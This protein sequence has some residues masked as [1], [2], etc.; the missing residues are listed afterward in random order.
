[1]PPGLLV[2]PS[3]GWGAQNPGCWSCWRGGGLCAGSLWG[4]RA[5]QL[6]CSP[7][8]TP[9]TTSTPSPTTRAPPWGDTTQPTARAPCPASGTASTTPGEPGVGAASRDPLL[10]ASHPRCSQLSS[11]P[12]AVSRRCPRAT[13]AAV[14][15]TCSS[16]SWP[17]RPPACSQPCLPGDPLCHPSEPAPLG[18]RHSAPPEQ[19][20]GEE[21]TPPRWLLGTARRRARARRSQRPTEEGL[22]T[23]QGSGSSG[24]F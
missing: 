12:C 23:R 11:P 15:P 10:R 16:T 21:E 20:G 19:E 5:E 6:P 17:A 22:V 4:S 3:E 1:M 2:S 24:T 18:F 8:T 7:Q 13:C 9:F 14:M